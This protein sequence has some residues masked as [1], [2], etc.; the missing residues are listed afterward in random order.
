MARATDGRERAVAHVGGGRVALCG[1]VG[2][3]GPRTWPF[4]R[5]LVRKPPRTRCTPAPARARV[6]SAAAC[7]VSLLLTLLARS[8]L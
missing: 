5:T 1:P 4:G 7:A 2:V 3:A 8:L 6:C